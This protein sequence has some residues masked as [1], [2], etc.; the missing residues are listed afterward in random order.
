MS[1]PA[2]GDLYVASLKWLHWR[3]DWPTSLF[4]ILR[5]VLRNDGINR[6]P[7][8]DDLIDAIDADEEIARVTPGETRDEVSSVES[9]IFLNRYFN[10]AFWCL[11]L[12]N[13]LSF[14][15]FFYFLWQ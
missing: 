5:L 9:S 6:A 8:S 15:V 13:K 3:F 14:G 10:H 4:Q 2:E 11:Q 12:K 1:L 7:H